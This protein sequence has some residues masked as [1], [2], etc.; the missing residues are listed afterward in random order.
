MLKGPP[1]AFPVQS[2]VVWLRRFTEVLRHEVTAHSRSGAMFG[3]VYLQC[4]VW[5]KLTLTFEAALPMVILKCFTDVNKVNHDTTSPVCFPTRDLRQLSTHL[6]NTTGERERLHVLLQDTSSEMEQVADLQI[7]GLKSYFKPPPKPVLCIFPRNFRTGLPSLA[8]CC[9]Y[10]PA[11]RSDLPWGWSRLSE[12]IPPLPR[13]VALLSE[14][15]NE[16]GLKSINV[17]LIWSVQ[18]HLTVS[19]S[20]KYTVFL[21]AEFICHLPVSVHLH[22]LLLHYVCNEF[23]FLHCREISPSVITQMLLLVSSS[24]NSKEETVIFKCKGKRCFWRLCS[25]QSNSKYIT[26]LPLWDP[27]SLVSSFY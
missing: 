23:S 20:T 5:N 8:I 9:H 17:I 16:P 10:C 1:K 21:F 6:L 12:Q 22:S 11:V 26:F 27:W 24:N 2:S 13:K 14:D 4:M 18:R 15:R 3:T 19:F 25:V 7:C